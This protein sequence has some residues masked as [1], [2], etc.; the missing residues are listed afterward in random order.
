MTVAQNEGLS[1][2][3]LVGLTGIDR[4]TLAD[5]VQRLQRKGLLHRRRTKEDA[6][7]YSVKLTDAGRR[8]LATAA[9]L[10]TRV[11]R[12]ILDALPANRREEF[13]DALATIV[14]SLERTEPESPRVFHVTAR[15]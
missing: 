9:P 6:R 14:S 15:R 7:A 11:D 4:S 12:R 8:V 2:T 1:Q 5:V 3:G 13:M 10:T